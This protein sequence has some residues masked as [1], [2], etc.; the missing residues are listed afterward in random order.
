MPEVG[1]TRPRGLSRSWQRYF[2]QDLETEGIGSI[3][4][5]VNARDGAT[6]NNDP[7][8]GPGSPLVARPSV[9]REEAGE[10]TIA[11]VVRAPR[12]LLGGHVPQS[13]HPLELRSLVGNLCV[14]AGRLGLLVF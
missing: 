6:R 11:L 10:Q 1:D 13:P 7:L 12:L 9:E 3:A 8:E 5:Q 14:R 2:L 4:W